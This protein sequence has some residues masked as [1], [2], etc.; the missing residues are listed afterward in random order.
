LDALDPSYHNKGDDVI[1]NID[2]FIHVGRHKWDV[3]CSSLNRDPIYEIKGHIQIKNVEL[4]YSEQP[5]AIAIDLDVCQHED[6][7][8]KKN[9]NHLG[10]NYCNI[11]AMIY[12][13]VLEVWTHII[14]STWIYYM[15]NIFN[16]LCAL[17]LM[18]MRPLFS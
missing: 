5:Y 11:L 9:P 8:I 13:H 1:E 7:I 12:S 18:K 10:V 16:H 6:D 17:N 4:F 14:L 3:I 2:D 15:N